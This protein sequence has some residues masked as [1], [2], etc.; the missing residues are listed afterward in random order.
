GSL[1]G[2][3]FAANSTAAVLGAID[4][5]AIRIVSLTVTESGYYLNAAT[6][7][8]DPAHPLVTHDLADPTHPRSTIG[9]I[10]EA[11]RRRMALG[12]PAFTSLSCDNIQHNGVVLRDAVL[13]F[14][15]LRDPHLADWI[16]KY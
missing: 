8:L 6:K 14:A 15:R 5:P 16:E 4:D 7:Q 2:L 11:Y 1:A 10:V 3:L 12:L 9:L 13:A